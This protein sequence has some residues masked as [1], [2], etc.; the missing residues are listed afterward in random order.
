MKNLATLPSSGKETRQGSLFSLAR[1][2]DE[3]RH[4]DYWC[5]P[6]GLLVPGEQD[7]EEEEENTKE[8]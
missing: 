8:K 3:T 7:E 5:L 4:I 1:D 6:D 2:E